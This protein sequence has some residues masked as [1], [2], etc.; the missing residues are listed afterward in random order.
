VPV[1]LA[2][3]WLSAATAAAGP[4]P[5]SLAPSVIPYYT[6]I[7]ED[8]AGAGL[9]TEQGLA[10]LR[11][12]GF[13]IV[14]DLRATTEGTES[15]RAAVEAAGL[16]YVAVPFTPETFRRAD[17][18]TVARVLDE[19]GRG[20]VLIHCAT[21]NRVG[22]VCTAV[23]V[24]RGRPYDE[25]EAEGRRIGLRTPAMIAAVKR[26]LGRDQPVH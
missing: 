15:E 5:E 23:E 13:A 16:R 7:R 11:E 8:V 22:G 6:L 1:L 12:L 9:P 24:S 4:I 10:Q 3:A 20:P 26:A 19:K 2:A 14:I 21:A 17:A 18:E 25:A